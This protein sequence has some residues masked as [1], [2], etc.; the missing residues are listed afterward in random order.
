MIIKNDIMKK[1]VLFVIESLGCGGAEKSLVSLL[2]LLDRRK[3]DL[4]IWMIHTE[5]AFKHLLPHDIIVVGQ[6]KYNVFELIL[7]RLS[8]LIY[9]VV[10]RLNGKIG[11][12]EYWG[13]TFY[14]CRGW[15]IKAPRG[16]WDVVFAYHQGFVTYVVADKFHDCK[17]VG[18]VNADIFKTGYNILFNSKF[19]RQYDCICPVSDILHGLMDERMPEFSP[20]YLTVWDIINPSVTRELSKQPV[21]NLKSSSDECVFVTTGRLHVLKGYDMAVEAARF[22]KKKCLKFKWFFIGEG[23]ERNNLKRMIASYELQNNVILLGMQTNPYP[24]MAQADVYVQTSRHEGFG[25]TIA[26]AKIL[27]LPIV[28]TNFDVIYNQIEH[29]K[30]GLI[31]DMDGDSIGEQILRLVQNDELRERIK[32]AVLKEENTTYLTEVAKVENLIDRLTS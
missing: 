29:E 16:Q 31:A 4:Y 14:K 13:E 8:S 5:G 26:E 23:T 12:N 3:Y 22:L 1:K 24:Y 6:P 9:S 27:G 28:S 19:Y 30:N 25:M 18:W 15:A 32:S 21:P 7:Y 20:K 2:S 10:L 17:K 11:K